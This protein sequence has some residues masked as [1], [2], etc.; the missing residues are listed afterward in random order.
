[1]TNPGY[2]REAGM[3]LRCSGKMV[4]DG[5]KEKECICPEG[6][7]CDIGKDTCECNYRLADF[8]HDQNIPIDQRYYFTV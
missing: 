1:M 3:C 8:Y 6:E 7:T 4:Q 5:K 2:Y